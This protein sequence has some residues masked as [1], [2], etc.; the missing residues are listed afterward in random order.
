MCL[1]LCLRYFCF[2]C[3]VHVSRFHFDCDRCKKVFDYSDHI[4]LF[5]AHYLTPATLEFTY[6]LFVSNLRPFDSYSPSVL[7]IGLILVVTGR[8]LLFTGMFF[9]TIVENMMAIGVFVGLV[10]LPLLY[11]TKLRVFYSMFM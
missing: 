10:L 6:V 9:H 8:T 3:S 7:S 11:F 4:V 2:W 1:C 5:L